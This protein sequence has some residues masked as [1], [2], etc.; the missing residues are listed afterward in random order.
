ML[1][2]LL[3][4]LAA[5]PLCAAEAD[6]R[7]PVFEPYVRIEDWDLPLRL[8]GTAVVSRRFLPFYSV[9]LYVGRD[10][11]D[12]DKLLRG[13]MPC[14]VAIHWLA[15]SV[16]ASDAAAYWHERLSQG[17]TDAQT[18]NRLRPSIERLIRAF[19]AAQRDDTLV[20]EYHPDRGLRVWSNGKAK[21]Q[22][23]GLDLNSAVLAIWL[24]P[25]VP[26][27]VRH[28]LL[29]MAIPDPSQP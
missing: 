28:A 27:E 23:A 29:G 21:G 18:R 4:A 11:A 14:R 15:P 24:D 26:A 25:K 6:T 2:W 9:A 5:A 1:L 13:M 19:G 16:S 3:L 17:I 20:L 12:P 7:A 22:F 10:A 8:S